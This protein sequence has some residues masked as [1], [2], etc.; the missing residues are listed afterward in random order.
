MVN[1]YKILGLENYA[2]VEQVKQAYKAKIKLYHP[3]VSTDA[4]AEEMTRYLN[5]AK[6]QL[7]SE[8]QK[9]AYDRQLKIAYLLEIQRLHTAAKKPK[10][11]Y[12]QTLSRKDREEK[13]EEAKKL[14]IK[15]KY[16][17][18]I[19]KFPLSL[20]II[21][22]CVLLITGLQ[23]I[24]THHFKQWGS[25]DYLFTVLGYFTF[26]LA[27]T[28]AAN[29]TYTYFLVKSIH[30]P[31]RFDYERSIGKYFVIACILG[32]LAVEGLNEFRKHYLLHNYYDYTVGVIDFERSVNGQ[33][34]VTYQVGTE[35]YRRKLDGD[36]VDIVRL[37]NRRTIIKYAKSAP[38]ISAL[39][40]LSEANNIPKSL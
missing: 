31:I 25:A 2:T 34:A 17:S 5:L 28:L 33:V 36:Y 1:Y 24:F 19:A 20:R 26:F 39:V 40:P 29:E 30:K 38:V 7:D 14:K 4:D 16:E 37:S 22:L 27:T 18:G 23:I 6:E 11:S 8:V 9:N 32:V 15:Q 10:K 35:V 3:D 13:L 21:G 12:W